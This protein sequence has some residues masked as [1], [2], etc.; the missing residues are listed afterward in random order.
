MAPSLVA[1]KDRPIVK[2]PNANAAWKAKK[3][4]LCLEEP[5]K[6]GA[7]CDVKLNALY[8]VP[9]YSSI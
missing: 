6:C 1:R 9:L 7:V 5:L 4:I 3:K 8:R 2:P